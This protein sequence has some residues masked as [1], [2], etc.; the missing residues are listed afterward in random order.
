MNKHKNKHLQGFAVQRHAVLRAPTY[1]SSDSLSSSN[2]DIKATTVVSVEIYSVFQRSRRK[3]SAG[4][5]ALVFQ[6]YHDCICPCF[7]NKILR[8]EGFSSDMDCWHVLIYEWCMIGPLLQR[9]MQIY[10]NLPYMNVGILYIK[11]W[12]KESRWTRGARMFLWL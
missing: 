7:W 5:T 2:E 10:H 11:Q 8:A 3:S 4:K 1:G 9:Q 12:E 6:N